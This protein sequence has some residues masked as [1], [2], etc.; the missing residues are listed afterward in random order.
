MMNVKDTHDIEVNISDYYGI[1]LN[2][3]EPNVF[4][5]SFEKNTNGEISEITFNEDNPV[6]ITIKN[7]DELKTLTD[8]VDFIRKTKEHIVK[9]SN[10]PNS[11][12]SFIV[13]KFRFT[14]KQ[15]KQ[16]N[17]LYVFDMP[18]VENPALDSESDLGSTPSTSHFNMLFQNSGGILEPIENIITNLYCDTSGTVKYE[19]DI[20]ERQSNQRITF[21]EELFAKTTEQYNHKITNHMKSELI[22]LDI[23]N[24]LLNIEFSMIDTT[25][26]YLLEASSIKIN[27]NDIYNKISLL[28]ENLSDQ[29]RDQHIINYIVY[30][31]NKKVQVSKLNPEFINEDGIKTWL[32]NPNKHTER[33]NVKPLW[34]YNHNRSDSIIIPSSTIKSKKVLEIN[35]IIKE[36]IIINDENLQ[37]YYNKHKNNNLASISN[38]PKANIDIDQIIKKKLFLKGLKNFDYSEVYGGTSGLVESIETKIKFINDNG[39]KYFKQYL[40]GEFINHTLNVLSNDMYSEISSICYKKER[41]NDGELLNYIKKVIEQTSYVVNFFVVSNYNMNSNLIAALEKNAQAN[42]NGTN[43]ANYRKYIY[44]TQ[45]NILDTF[46]KYFDEV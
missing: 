18:G 27:Y 26:I 1:K 16:N 41:T 11:S 25:T 36:S 6:F 12:R 24:S 45:F 13:Y 14:Q 37:E 28:F 15:S 4:V 2:E 21:N 5:M 44:D 46:K 8:G 32:T 20:V 3:K 40:E 17:F 34:K 9:T 33:P 39:I 42:V 30:D 35:V 43:P 38:E 7:V 29:E 19:P 31:F 23:V 22:K 10:N